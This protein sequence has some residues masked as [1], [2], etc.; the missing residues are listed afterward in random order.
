MKTLRI[1]QPLR[2]AGPLQLLPLQIDGMRLLLLTFFL[3]SS[4]P[5]SGDLEPAIDQELW[6]GAVFFPNFHK[7]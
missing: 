3:L 6:A 1:L 4:L 2:G 5:A 7:K